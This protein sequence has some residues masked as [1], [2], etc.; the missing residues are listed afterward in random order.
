[1]IFSWRLRPLA[2]ISLIFT[3][4]KWLDYIDCFLI[5]GKIKSTKIFYLKKRKAAQGLSE[6]LRQTDNS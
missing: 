2:L 3:V 4:P 1:M 6:L 5:M